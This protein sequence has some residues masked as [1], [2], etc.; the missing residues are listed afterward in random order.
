MILDRKKIDKLRTSKGSFNRYIRKWVRKNSRVNL[1]KKGWID[2]LCGTFISNIEYEKLILLRDAH[3]KKGLSKTEKRAIK[4]KNNSILKGKSGKTKYDLYKAKYYSYLKSSKW[5]SI[6]NSIIE[7]RK[8]CERCYSIQELQ[9]HHK[10]YENV[11]NEKDEDLEL[12]CK[13]CHRKEHN[14]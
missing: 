8:R 3:P 2:R 9:V 5:K 12:L 14:L 7:D 1:K 11:F 4:K 10:T 13:S 6:R